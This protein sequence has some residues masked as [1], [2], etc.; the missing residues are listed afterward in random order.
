MITSPLVHTRFCFWTFLKILATSICLALKARSL[1]YVRDILTSLADRPQRF[2]VIGGGFAGVA[3][4]WNLLAMTG[5]SR[6]TTVDLYDAAGLAGGGSGAAAGL[7][8]PYTPRGKVRIPS[9]SYMIVLWHDEMCLPQAMSRPRL[10]RMRGPITDPVGIKAEIQQIQRTAADV[11]GKS[12]AALE[13]AR[14]AHICD[15]ADICC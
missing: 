12:V 15:E 10:L 8:H 5:G 14:G 11:T 13:G 3:V 6:P 1:S 4:A 7:L 9:C 2:A